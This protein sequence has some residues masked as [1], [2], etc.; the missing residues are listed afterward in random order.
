[1][2]VTEAE[3][4]GLAVITGG[5]QLPGLP[6]PQG[7]T[8]QAV[9]A[10]EGLRVKGVVDGGGRV[11]R[12]GVVPVRAVE[13]YR[14]AVRHVYVNQVKASVNSDG[15]L[16]VLHPVVG[17]WQLARMHPAVLMLALIKADPCLRRGG[18]D[19]SVGEWTPVTGDEWTATHPPDGRG[20]DLVVRATTGN[21]TSSLVVYAVSGETGYV[22]DLV[23][24]RGRVLPVGQ[25]R[26][27]IADLVGF[28]A[29]GGD[30]HV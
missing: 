21:T 18:T 8:S 14:Q 12:F 1:M 27:Q 2:I 7:G 5:G 29:D 26:S 25:I 4:T 19:V 30:S 13:Q 15:A 20:T 11:T 9:A 3:L 22:F 28:R 17:G 10:L 16:T 6:A 24:G 23:G